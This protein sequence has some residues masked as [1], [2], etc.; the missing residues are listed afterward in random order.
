MKPEEYLR[1]NREKRLTEL[2]EFLRFPSISGRSEHT[3]DVLACAEWLNAHLKKI[4]FNTS[5]RPTGGHPVVYAENILSP[6]K[7]TVLYYGHYDFQPVEPL[8]LWKTKPFEPTIKGEYLIARGATDDKGQLFTHVKALEAYAAT[9]TELPVNVKLLYEGE[10]ESGAENLAKFVKQNKELLKAD[11][12]VVSDSSQFGKNK[13]A[14]TFGLRGVVSL[15]V[16]ITGPSHDLHSGGFGGAVPNPVNVLARIISKLHDVDGHVLI[17]G[18][19]DDIPPLSDWEREQFAKL[20]FNKDEYV[21]SVGSRG[22]FGE[23]GY[24][25][26]EQV[27]SRPT[28]D[29]NGI[30]GGYQGEGGKTIIPSWASAKITLRLVP[31]QNPDDILAKVEKYIRKVCPD[32]VDCEI[33]IH[34][35]AGAVEVPTDGPWL[36]A[37]GRA[38]KKG[39][40]VEPVF[41]KEGGSIPIVGTFKEVLG[42]DTLLLGWGQQDDG[43]HSP[44][45]RFSINDFERGCFASLALIDELSRVKA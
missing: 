35:G 30:T 43:A 22:L 42:I 28:C 24:S 5:I 9:A 19:Y 25:V 15:E 38:I 1:E 41:M 20:P 40:G 17:D 10:E 26:Y 34:G 32:Y 29:V 2:M 44:N 18:F 12:I 36:D 31:D 37:A 6:D 11:I 45:E 14:V 8:D 33:D 27:W 7:L 39:F 3:T 4:G 21:K 13:P 23:K 16:K